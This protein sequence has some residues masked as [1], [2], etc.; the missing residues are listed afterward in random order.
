M[1]DRCLERLHLPK[2]EKT[3]DVLVSCLF[4]ADAHSIPR[5]KIP[6][7]SALVDFPQSLLDVLENN[8]KPVY[9]AE[10]LPYRVQE[11]LGWDRQKSKAAFF[12]GPE[13]AGAMAEAIKHLTHGDIILC[14]PFCGSGALLGPITRKLGGKKVSKIY[15]FEIEPISIVAA[16]ITCAEAVEWDYHKL[17][18]ELNDSFAT[19]SKRFSGGGLFGNKIMEKADVIVTNPPYLPWAKVSDATRSTSARLLQNS[20]YILGDSNFTTYGVFLGDL[21]L[22][23]G[24]VYCAVLPLS[25]FFNEKSALTV[26][27]FYK[28]YDLKCMLARSALRTPYSLSCQASDVL[29]IAR[30][31]HGNGRYYAGM[32]PD[33]VL[34]QMIEHIKEPIDI[35]GWKAKGIDVKSVLGEYNPSAYIAEPE[36]AELV[37]SFIEKV[38]DK[39]K[40]PGHMFLHQG[41]VPAPVKFWFLPNN[42]YRDVKDEGEFLAVSEEGHPTQHKLMIPKK[43]TVR[44]FLRPSE[45][46]GTVIAELEHYGLLFD[47]VLSEGEEEYIASFGMSGEG[48]WWLKYREEVERI[49]WA[50]C[51]LSRILNLAVAYYAGVG[52]YTEQ[53]SPPVS[54]LIRFKTGSDLDDRVLISWY[55]SLPFMAILIAFGRR[56]REET[57][58]I[59]LSDYEAFPIPDLSKMSNEDKERFGAHVY[60]LRQVPDFWDNI[61]RPHDLEWGAWLGIPEDDLESLSQALRRSRGRW[62]QLLNSDNAS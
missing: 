34:T 36:V 35:P 22:K 20:G 49:M 29:V 11:C 43:N 21:L 41:T 2:N 31:D 13:A 14:D 55:N 45:S 1:Q 57:M 40:Q 59:T 52:F 17:V 19:V 61:P 27:L 5:E 16:Y 26:D 12:T 15:G 6:V 62:F 42:V 24:G 50:K 58:Y 25:M 4:Y 56:L 23:R 30:K 47:K 39:L 9:T 10:E 3:F 48:N 44:V 60:Q 28:Q 51:H 54:A 32:V 33:D 37:E 46:K 53:D 7:L 38:G 18:F 8:A